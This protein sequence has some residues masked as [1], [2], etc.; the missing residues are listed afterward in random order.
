LNLKECLAV[1]FEDCSFSVLGGNGFMIRWFQRTIT[2]RSEL[3]I[4]V[5]SVRVK[6]RNACLPELEQDFRAHAEKAVYDPEGEYYVM[7][8]MYL[9]TSLLTLVLCF[10][11]RNREKREKWKDERTKE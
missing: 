7:L 9:P 6:K 8:L 11:W 10:K 3:E 2:E 4:D 5:Q 1:D